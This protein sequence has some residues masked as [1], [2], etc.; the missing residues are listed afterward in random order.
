[1]FHL[2]KDRSKKFDVQTCQSLIKKV[3]EKWGYSTFSKDMTKVHKPMVNGKR[4]DMTPYVLENENQKDEV[5]VYSYIKPYK[6]KL[7]KEEEEE[8]EHRKNNPYLPPM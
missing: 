4:V 6:S 5:D 7:P 2:R 1:M 3:F 8:D